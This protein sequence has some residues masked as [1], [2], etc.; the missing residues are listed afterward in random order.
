MT[1]LGTQFL[2]SVNTTIASKAQKKSDYPV[3]HW[4]RAQIAVMNR[5][6]P[7]GALGVAN[8]C[9]EKLG[10]PQLTD[11]AASIVSATEKRGMK[12]GKGQQ[13]LTEEQK[14]KITSDRYKE[15]DE[16]TK[17][18]A[19]VKAAFEEAAAAN[20]IK[21][22]GFGKLGV[23]A[24]RAS[25]DPPHVGGGD[26][27]SGEG[28]ED[29]DCGSGSRE[30]STGATAKRKRSGNGKVSA[31]GKGPGKGKGSGKGKRKAATA[32]E[33]P[34]YTAAGSNTER[35]AEVAVDVRMGSE[36]EGT[37]CETCLQNGVG[38]AFLLSENHKRKGSR[39]CAEMHSKWEKQK[40]G[41]TASSVL[42]AS[43]S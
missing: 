5:S 30:D 12:V 39:K 11:P 27:D 28:N 35:N 25:L 22:Y 36:V 24:S 34:E 42:Q 8:R 33:S 13:H 31:R 18:T 23:A 15:R 10:L 1:D 4:A 20:P 43:G 38:R 14:A 9:R 29:D 6:L 37:G 2:E 7:C 32:F 26:H 40:G 41:G 17:N 16:V 3:T 21:P 19:R